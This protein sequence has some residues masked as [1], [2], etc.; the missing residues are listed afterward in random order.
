MRCISHHLTITLSCPEKFRPPNLTL[1][2]SSTL[3]L[4]ACISATFSLNPRGY[5]RMQPSLLFD[6]LILPRHSS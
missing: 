1:L 4:F 5:R 2:I 6:E 3:L